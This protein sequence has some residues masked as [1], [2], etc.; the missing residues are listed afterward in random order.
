MSSLPET[1]GIQAKASPVAHGRQPDL[2]KSIVESL[3]VP[4][5]RVDRSGAL[6]YANARMLELLGRPLHEAIGLRAS[7]LYPAALALAYTEDDQ[8]VMDSG[9]PLSRLQDYREPATGTF[10]QVW[11]SKSPV[12]DQQ[13]HVVGLQGLFDDISEH[14]QSLHAFQLANRVLDST[15]QALMITDTEGRIVRVNAAFESITGWSAP[16]VL[17]KTPQL[18]SSGQHSRE[19]YQRMWEALLAQGHWEGELLNRRRDGSL[20]T[21]HISIS[22]LR[23]D[24]DHPSHYVALF[25]DISD[26]KAAQEEIQH[27]AQHDALTGLPNRLLLTD[28]LQQAISQAERSGQRVA[29]LFM[30]L[31]RFKEVN[32]VH[33]HQMGDLLLKQAAERIRHTLRGSDTVARLGGDEFVALLPDLHSPEE[34]LVVGENLRQALYQP[35][36][37]GGHSLQLSASIGIASFPDDS[38]DADDLM[39]CADLAMYEAKAAGRNRVQYF[40]EELD[41]RARSA[42]QM[43]SELRRALHERELFLEFQPQI[44]LATGAVASIEALVRWQHPRQGRVEP[45]T[46]I[47]HAEESRLIRP[48]G[49]QILDLACSAR[50]KLRR[51]LPENVPIAIN[52][53]ARQLSDPRFLDAFQETIERH[54][55]PGTQVEL[56]LTESALIE[57]MDAAR[58]VLQRLRLLGVKVAVDDF[59]TGYSNLALLHRLPLSRIKIDRSFVMDLDSRR[60]ALAIF[61]AICAMAHSLGLHVVAEGVEQVEQLEVIRSLGC[62]AAQGYALARPMDL[63]ALQRWLKKRARSAP[64]KP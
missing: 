41:V 20:F 57:E 49:E 44:D 32:D 1:P 28:R 36:E 43:E 7:E 13:G 4:L 3:A 12:R 2:F 18:L 23:D 39:R 33:G 21:E 14:L 42:A 54:A 63:P 16:E 27:L 62:D 47:R 64:P 34:A 55:L 46:F 59:G 31:D 30:D 11:V 60:S 9:L 56:E 37:I 5:Y 26:R 48:I 10:R 17:G 51:Q 35:F 40:R 24:S 22:C 52:L 19:F 8:Q 61:R 25:S 58:N 45:L 6:T 53:S 15:Q 50:A 38:A 29:L